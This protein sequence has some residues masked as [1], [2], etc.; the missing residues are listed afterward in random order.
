MTLLIAET[1]TSPACIAGLRCTASSKHTVL[2]NDTGSLCSLRSFP[3]PKTSAPSN[4]SVAT[5]LFMGVNRLGL[6][7]RISS[8]AGQ[9][10]VISDRSNVHQNVHQD[11]QTDG[12]GYVRIMPDSSYKAL[13]LWHLHSDSDPLP[14]IKAD[15]IGYRWIISDSGVLEAAPFPEQQ[16]ASD[17]C[18]PSPSH[19]RCARFD[20]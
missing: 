8:E 10:R 3:A 14:S 18:L 15:T 7:P 4:I 13:S 11:I 1:G 20:G 19:Q 2:P 16:A 17:F 12:V 5:N 6:I 9:I